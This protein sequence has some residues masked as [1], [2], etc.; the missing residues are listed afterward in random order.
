MAINLQSPKPGT[1]GNMYIC[2][3]F[4]ITLTS[5]PVYPVQAHFPWVIPDQTAPVLNLD[6]KMG[7]SLP[8]D[9]VL[10]QERIESVTLI[11]PDG[12]QHPISR[13]ETG[14]QHQVIADGT[15]V[16][17]AAQV[18]G[19][20]SRTEEGEKTGSRK[21]HPNAL[22]CNQSSNSMKAVIARGTGPAAV[23][24]VIGYELEIIPL[25]NPANLQAGGTFPL[26]VLYQG[27]PWQGTLYATYEG[28]QASDEADHPVT[29]TTDVNGKTV[30]T[31]PTAAL[32]MLRVTVREEYPDP[33]VCDRRTF[34]STLTFRIN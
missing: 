24:Q 8:S 23:N 21:D 10:E 27:Q 33:A 6:V 28:Y 29:A 17:A 3:F 20:R 2:L 12:S 32:W 9:Q 14:W 11:T 18:T 16:L 7:H 25:H 5:I 34:T 4:V 30:L 13:A 19:Y 15:Y 1:H 22:S 31:L 26:Q